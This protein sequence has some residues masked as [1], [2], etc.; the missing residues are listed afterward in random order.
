MYR[1]IN[2]LSFLPVLFLPK[3]LIESVNNDFRF[4]EKPKGNMTSA[5]KQK[6]LKMVI[7]YQISIR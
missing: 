4:K 2:D 5:E 7:F 1:S 6:F 3:K